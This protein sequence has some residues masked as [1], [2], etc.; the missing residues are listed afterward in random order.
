[1]ARKAEP[2][3][4]NAA[5]TKR[6]ILAA[7]K[8]CFSDIG[9][10]NTGI[11]DVAAVAG[12]NYALVGRYYG[13]KAGLLEAALDAMM[14]TERIIVADRTRFGENMASI[15]AMS[16]GIE[17]TSTMTVLSAADPV[18][19]A[20]AMRLLED[21]I[22]QPLADWLGPP[23]AH[24]RA[25][26]IAMLGAGFATHVRLVPLL[27][28]EPELTMGTPIVRWLANAL[29]SI[30]DEP[31]KWRAD[32]EQNTAVLDPCIAELLSKKDKSN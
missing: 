10:A 14:S 2:T 4:R 24:D 28:R 29:Q 23:Y 11:R 18:A 3:R 7:A 9:Y 27:G 1:M 15:I 31:E 5:E 30:V 21:K 13:S 22:V 19:R 17:T 32:P 8:Q 25:V 20:V 16:I 6:R 26:A 12:V